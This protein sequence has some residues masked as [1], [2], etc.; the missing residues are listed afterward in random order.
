MRQTTDIPLSRKPIQH[1]KEE[2]E[3]LPA[4]V[5][6]V[7]R[8][9]GY[10]DKVGILPRTLEGHIRSQAAIDETIRDWMFTPQPPE[11]TTTAA[12]AAAAAAASA[13]ASMLTAA[14]PVPMA[15]FRDYAEYHR[16]QEICEA[17]RNCADAGHRVH[18]AEWNDKVHSP[19]LELVLA[20]TRN[21]SRPLVQHNITNV[22]V[23]RRFRDQEQALGDNKIDYGVF[24]AP[25]GGSELGQSIA[26][27]QRGQACRGNADP[28]LHALHGFEPDRPLGLSIE[29][30]R[31]RGGDA[32]GPSQLAMCTRAHFRAVLDTLGGPSSSSYADDIVHPLIDLQGTTWHASFAVRR[33]NSMTIYGDIRLGSTETPTDCYALLAGLRCLCDWIRDD[34]WDWWTA[35]LQE[36]NATGT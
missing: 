10:R 18:E 31:N 9:V 13:A 23:D 1:L 35:R 14:G 22:R 32:N 34:H 11:S 17:T 7:A 25:P 8:L 29:T 6:L 19:I 3:R 30:K 15:I 5:A 16:I 27:H 28:Q 24:L 33:G 20:G 2:E 36:P 26:S 21:S 4:L 12:A